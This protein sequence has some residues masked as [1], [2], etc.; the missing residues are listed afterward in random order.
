[1]HQQQIIIT[2]GASNIQQVLSSYQ[3]KWKINT[4]VPITFKI[5]AINLKMFGITLYLKR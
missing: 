3:S 4:P 5:M 2:H 1:M